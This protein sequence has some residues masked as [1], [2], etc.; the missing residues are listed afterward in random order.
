MS[1][2]AT[3]TEDEFTEGTP[4]LVVLRRPDSEGFL[5]AV[6]T[7]AFDGPG[8]WGIIIADLV[9]HVANAYAQDGLHGGAV[10][11]IVRSVVLQELNAPTEKVTPMRWATEDS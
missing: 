1:S 3:L 7:S 10:Q 11:Q 2:R 8:A 6:D 5:T 4:V 9:Q